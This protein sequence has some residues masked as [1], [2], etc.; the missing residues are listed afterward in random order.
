MLQLSSVESRM[1][2]RGSQCT[3]ALIA[4]FQRHILYLTEA[5]EITLAHRSL[6]TEIHVLDF[7]SMPLGGLLACLKLSRGR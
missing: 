3:V 2:G 1:G 5:S 7:H 6:H 4:S